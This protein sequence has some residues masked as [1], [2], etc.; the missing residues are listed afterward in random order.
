[1]FV[2]NG[3]PLGGCCRP[4]GMCGVD[5]QVIRLGC[6]DPVLVGD[7]PASPCGADNG[8]APADVDTGTRG[9]DSVPSSETPAD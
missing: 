8:Q 2:M 1:V 6:N 3:F 9:S 4:N 5:L 7:V